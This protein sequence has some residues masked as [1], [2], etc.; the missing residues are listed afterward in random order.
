MPQDDSDLLIEHPSEVCAWLEEMVDDQAPLHL[1]EPGGRH[2]TLQPLR[3]VRTPAVLELKLPGVVAQLPDWL[4]D[5]PVHAHALLDR[6]RLDFD[7]GRRALAEHE[8]LPV[9]RLDLPAR[10]RR[11][12]RR[13]AFRVQPASVHHPRAL[14]PR[15]SSLPLRLR[16]ADLSAGGVGILWADA[17]PLPQPGDLLPQVDI[18]LARDLRIQVRLQVQHVRAAQADQPPLVGCAF[19]ELS[20]MAERQLSLHLNQMQRRQRNLER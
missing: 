11:H 19:V 3:F 5:G 2:L 18:E 14:L 9:L 20:P 10:L 8:G 7:L 13:Q 12:Q 4:L 16:T 6:I 17:L 1:E 15:G